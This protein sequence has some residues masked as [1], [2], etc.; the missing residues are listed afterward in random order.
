MALYST[1][2]RINTRNGIRITVRLFSL[3]ASYSISKCHI[4]VFLKTGFSW[5]SFFFHDLTAQLA[6]GLLC[7]VPWSHSFRHTTLGRT[8]LDEWSARGRDLYLPIHNTQK[9]QTSMSLEAFEPTNPPT[10]WRQTHTL[11]RTTTGID[12]LSGCVWHHRVQLLVFTAK[13]IITN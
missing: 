11:D 8:P 7:E 5:Y 6:L 1:F 13:E 12:H 9:R 10:E 2:L 4:C 3:F